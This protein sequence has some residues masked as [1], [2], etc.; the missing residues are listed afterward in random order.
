MD[1]LV[2]ALEGLNPLSVPAIF[3]ADTEASNEAIQGHGVRLP[4]LPAGC[5]L[6][7]DAVQLYEQGYL[8]R[9]QQLA[10]PTRQKEKYFLKAY[11]VPRWGGTELGQ[12][13]MQT[14]EEWLHATFQ[15]WWTMHG[16]RGIMS[17]VFHYAE[18]HGLWEPGSAL[19]LSRNDI[20]YVRR[21]TIDVVRIPTSLKKN[22]HK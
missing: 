10:R 12:M 22:L 9:E 2:E 13:N 19:S 11:I 14:I 16:V 20:Q 8:S 21:R 3:A 6:F 7:G 17:R 4:R 1:Q 5:P 18:G 15:S